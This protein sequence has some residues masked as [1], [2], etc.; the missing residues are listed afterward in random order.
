[1]SARVLIVDDSLTVRADLAEAFAARDYA[2][3][4]CATLAEARSALAESLEDT[5]Y[6]GSFVASAGS[7]STG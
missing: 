2:T 3:V 6:H 4:A 5:A 1:M 7:H